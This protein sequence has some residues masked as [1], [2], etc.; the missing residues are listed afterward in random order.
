MI[1]EAVKN[2]LEDS[3]GVAAIVSAR[4]YPIQLPQECTLPA[5]SFSKVSVFGKDLTHS[6]TSQTANSI[7][8]VSCWAKSVLA[9]KNLANAVKAAL[10]GYSGSVGSDTIFF[11][12]MVN[13]VDIFDPEVGVY[14]IPVDFELMHRDV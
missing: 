10:H 3:A 2:I 5:I 14:H 4:I 6:G 12:K 1:E 13:E 7:M 9:V 11:S 8:Q